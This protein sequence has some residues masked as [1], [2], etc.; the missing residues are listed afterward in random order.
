MTITFFSLE[1]NTKISIPQM[2]TFKSP[3]GDGGIFTCYGG[4]KNFTKRWYHFGKQVEKPIVYNGFLILVVSTGRVFGKFK[5]EWRISPVKAKNR[6]LV[7][8]Y[9]SKQKRQVGW[10][11]CY[12]NIK[13]DNTSSTSKKCSIISAKYMINGFNCPIK[14]HYF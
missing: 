5:Y 10:K 6:Q 2:Y 13:Y 4:R 14:S 8:R 3:N 1:K 11:M 12:N 7:K 9:N